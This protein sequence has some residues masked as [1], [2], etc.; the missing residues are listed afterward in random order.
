LRLLPYWYTRWGIRY[1]NN[2]ENRAVC[3]YLHPWEVDPGQP[4]LNG[5]M[6]ARIRHTFGLRGLGEKLRRLLKDFEFCPLGALVEELS[7]SNT[8]HRLSF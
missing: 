4:H 1:L 3:V 7:R 6:S 2:R 8:L 5:S